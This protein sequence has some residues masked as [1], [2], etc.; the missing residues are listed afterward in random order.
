MSG[1]HFMQRAFF[2][3]AAFNCWLQ[4]SCLNESSGRLSMNP[5]TSDDFMIDSM[6]WWVSSSS[7]TPTASDLSAIFFVIRSTL[8]HTALLCWWSWL[9]LLT[10]SGKGWYLRRC[11]DCLLMSC[12]NTYILYELPVIDMTV[13]CSLIS[14]PLLTPVE[15]NQQWSSVGDACSALCMQCTFCYPL[16]GTDSCYAWLLHSRKNGRLQI[17]ICFSLKCF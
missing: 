12:S 5:A 13:W 4:K 17:Q 14:L 15:L 3:V 16:E 2:C 11:N 9:S 1:C 10:S 6:F 8:L 7:V